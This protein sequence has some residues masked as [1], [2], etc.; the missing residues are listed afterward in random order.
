MRT[1]LESHGLPESL[2]AILPQSGR[3]DA[4]LHGR[5]D[6]RRYISAVSLVLG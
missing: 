3:Q 1:M 5:R 6:A 2:L 4:A